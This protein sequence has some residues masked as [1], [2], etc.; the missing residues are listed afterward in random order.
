MHCVQEY[1]IAELVHSFELDV[2]TCCGLHFKLQSMD[3]GKKL[4]M[5]WHKLCCRDQTASHLH[6]RYPSLRGD[7]ACV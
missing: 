1:A 3:G 2:V 6:L 7:I 4:P 5:T